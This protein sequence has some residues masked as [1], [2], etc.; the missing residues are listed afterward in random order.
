MIIIA[1]FPETMI[2]KE[3]VHDVCMYVRG[4]EDRH[5]TGKRGYSDN[6]VGCDQGLL[7]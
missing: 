2:K 6:N 5:G 7:A 3:E 4:W 1:W